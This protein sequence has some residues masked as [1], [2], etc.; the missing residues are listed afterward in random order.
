MQF[1]LPALVLANSTRSGSGCEVVDV[2]ASQVVIVEGGDTKKEGAIGGVA[3]E[4]G[5]E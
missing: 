4:E 2:G 5:R 1:D 3:S